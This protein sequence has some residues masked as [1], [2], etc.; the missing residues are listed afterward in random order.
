MIIIMI[1]KIIITIIV[2]IENNS[3]NNNK[4]QPSYI[5]YITMV[6]PTKTRWKCHLTICYAMNFR[7]WNGSFSLRNI[8]AE[9]MHMTITLKYIHISI[10]QNIQAL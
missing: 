5:I 9:D 6:S 1:I 2:T 3:N 4:K 8:I 7:V 10:Y